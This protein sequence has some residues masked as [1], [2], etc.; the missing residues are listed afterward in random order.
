MRNPI[1]R[2]GAIIVLVVAIVVAW[3]ALFTVRETEQAVVLRF[4]AVRNVIT[5]PG[6]YVKA[7]FIDVVLPV[8]KRVL[9]LDIPAQTVL[10]ADRQNLEVDA[11]SRYRIVDPL[12]FYQSVNNLTNANARLQ[13]F[14]NS[15]MR[16]VLANAS[17]PEIIRTNRVELMQRIQQIV[18]R[19]AEQLGIQVI[20]V[21]LTRVDLPTANSEA[22]FR[23]MQTEREREA[24]DLR[25]QGAQ[26]AASIRARADRD[27]VVILAE[28]NRTAEELRGAGDAERNRVLAGSYSVDPEFFAFY[29]SMLAYENALTRNENADSRIVIS[30]DSEFFR[31]FA[32]PSGRR[33]GGADTSLPP[34]AGA[35]PA[36]GPVS[37]AP[38]PLAP[39]PAGE[40]AAAT[41]TGALPQTDVGTAEDAASDEAADATGETATVP[42]TAAAPA[43]ALAQ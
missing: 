10:S 6:L 2:L 29:R 4:G 26:R 41:G 11:F 35:Q 19:Q 5:E 14:I 20:D 31:F 17:F 23:R 30:P 28:A 33:G 40:D 16:N 36:P 13:S 38:A 32:D 43:P 22:V 27:V 42:T 1:V 24:A 25:A 39:A 37:A 8:E 21:R 15:A 12:R 7:P 9:A 3:A 34:P 18:D